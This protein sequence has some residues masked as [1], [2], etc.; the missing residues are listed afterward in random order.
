MRK[1]DFIELFMAEAEA[2]DR[3]MA[4]VEIPDMPP[5]TKERIKE[6]I[7]NEIKK[8]NERKEP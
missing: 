4:G 3:E 5:G 7:D 2:I 6:R 8:R 1:Q